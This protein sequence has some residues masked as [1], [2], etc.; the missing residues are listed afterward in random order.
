MA[1]QVVWGVVIMPALAAPSPGERFIYLAIPGENIEAMQE[2]LRAGEK[3]RFD[4][5]LEDHAEDFKREVL[6]AVTFYPSLPPADH[7]FLKK[8]F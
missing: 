8:H 5:L 2:E 7:P 1:R 3:G 4:V 6:A